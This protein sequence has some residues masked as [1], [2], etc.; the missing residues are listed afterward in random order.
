MKK[1]LLIFGANGAL[2]KGITKTMLNK[3][4]DKIYLFDFEMEKQ[5]LERME[6]IEKISTGDLSIEKNVKDVIEAI[7]PSNETLFFLYSTVGGFAGGKTIQDTEEQE[8]DRMMNINLK[9]N[10]FIAKHFS[11][12]VEK[13][14][15]GS[16][17]F[18]AAETGISPE[19]EKASYGTSKSG[20][21]HLV[22][23][24]ALEGKSIKLSANAIAPFIIDTPAN[25]EWMHSTDY[26]EWVKTEEIGD[27]A[28][29]IFNHFYFISG[30]II[31]LYIRFNFLNTL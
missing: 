29:S 14:G 6:K 28:Y 3:D 12:L 17:C 9:S 13:S 20:L 22:K 4:Y 15:G 24:L 31:R 11:R 27:L 10:F 8:W 2:G 1:E 16:I 21:I 7:K 5:T 18:T 25:R 23:T 26:S 19:K 30:N